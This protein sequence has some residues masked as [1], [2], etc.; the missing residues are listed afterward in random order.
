MRAAIG[1]LAVRPADGLAVLTRLAGPGAGTTLRLRAATVAL[2]DGGEAG[3]LTALA[4]DTDEPVK[5]RTGAVEAL[6]SYRIDPARLI[7]LAR[8]ETTP[9]RIRIAAAM[10]LPIDD[11][12]DLLTG[13]A[14]GDPRLATR[15]A[16]IDT[17]ELVDEPAAGELFARLVCDRRIGSLR[18]RAVLAVYRDLLSE[19][20]AARMPE[21]RL[22]LVLRGPERLLSRPPASVT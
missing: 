11:A 16:A 19:E 20:N 5:L 21:G 2:S 18:R 14:T 4:F 12:V 3:P 1:L 6:A 8:A 9:S 7:G 22:R 13:I 17:L 10:A 15:I